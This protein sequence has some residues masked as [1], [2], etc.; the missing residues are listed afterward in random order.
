LAEDVTRLEHI[1]RRFEL[2]GREPELRPVR[3]AAVMEELQ[4]YLAARLPRIGPGVK[5]NVRI[6]DDLPPVRGHAVLLAWAVENVVK[7]A[8]DALAGRGGRITI[9][10]VEDGSDAV[11]L[12]IKDTGPGV[13]DEVRERLFEPGVTTKSGGWG[14][15]L[16]LTRRIV[17][18]VHGGELRLLDRR[19]SGATFEMKL[20]TAVG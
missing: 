8:V 20:P 5:L 6:P 4:R 3:L 12:R 2:I 1:S 14:V 7:N 16:T 18:G 13:S 10:A 19:P 15:G 9:Y 17:E 11:A